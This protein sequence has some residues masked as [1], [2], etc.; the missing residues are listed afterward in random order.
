MV[1]Q[2]RTHDLDDLAQAMKKASSS[3][4]RQHLERIMY[5]ILNTSVPV[6][7]LRLD[8]VRAIRSGDINRVR[9]IQNHIHNIRMNETNGRSYGNQKGE[10]NVR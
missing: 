9:Y 2:T 3:G 5:S 4:E 1:D 10:K 6:Q 8:L 7:S